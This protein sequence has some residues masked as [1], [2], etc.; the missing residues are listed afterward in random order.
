MVFLTDLASKVGEDAKDL[1]VRPK[2]GC[3]GEN[4][5]LITRCSSKVAWIFNSPNPGWIKERH[6]GGEVFWATNQNDRKQQ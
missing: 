5:E 4:S 3:V 6:P 2:D 1:K